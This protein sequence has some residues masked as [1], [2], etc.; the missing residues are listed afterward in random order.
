LPAVSATITFT[1]DFGYRDT[2]V[3]VVHGVLARL[4]P[5]ARVIDLTHGIPPQDVRAGAVALFSA[6]LHFP[7][8]TVHLAVVDPGVGT[9]RRPLVLR[10][11]GQWFVGPDNGLFALVAPPE[12]M[13]GCWLLD[14]PRYWLSPVSQTFHGRDIFAP[15]AA[16][17]VNG[18]PAGDLGTPATP[19]LPQL[20][21]QLGDVALGETV[22]TVLCADHFGNLVTN[23][24]QTAYW[25]RA[26]EHGTVT[27]WIGERALLPVRTYGDGCLAPDGGGDRPLLLRAGGS[28]LLEVAI[29]N[30]NAA[31][32]TGIRPGT[33]V[34]LL[35]NQRANSFNPPVGG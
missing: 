19:P 3:G 4:A 16:H 30:G 20:D 24:R 12:T 7:T 23:L 14:Q 34:R 31:L 6:C 11:G 18:V 5:A 33:P 27:A 28:G 1:S 9:D 26:V 17:L 13:E 29:S 8:G 2:Y 32:E 21:L 22:G 35:L 25:H 15:V 10:S